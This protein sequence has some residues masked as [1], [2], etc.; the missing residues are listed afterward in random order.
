MRTSS[1]VRLSTER[2]SLV[3]INMETPPSFSS[4]SVQLELQASVLCRWCCRAVETLQLVSFQGR[5]VQ[6]VIQ[7]LSGTKAGRGRGVLL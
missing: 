1:L 2:H 3:G 6:V 7:S 4:S 5:V